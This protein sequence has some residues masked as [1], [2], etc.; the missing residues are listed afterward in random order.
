MIHQGPSLLGLHTLAISYQSLPE[1]FLEGTGVTETLLAAAR[2]GGNRLGAYPTC[3]VSSASSDLVFAEQLRQDLQAQG[4][5]CESLPYDKDPATSEYV[6]KLCS[7][8][9]RVLLIFSDQMA[10][11]DSRRDKFCGDTLYLIQKWNGGRIVRL[12][13]NPIGPLLQR[14]LV[15]RRS[16]MDQDFT[17]WKEQERYQHAFGKLLRDLK[18]DA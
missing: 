10:T 1:T 8:Y 14:F 16:R 9:D 11:G 7:V 6:I 13:L 2:A 15:P 18:G 3:L 5:V 12:F 17:D 4:V